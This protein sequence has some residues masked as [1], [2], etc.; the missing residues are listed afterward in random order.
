MD[1]LEVAMMARMGSMV[2][3]GIEIGMQMVL[4]S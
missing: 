3:L 2:V 4:G 1:I